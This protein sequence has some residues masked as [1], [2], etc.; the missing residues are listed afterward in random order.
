M[1]SL[2][3]P[4]SALI[5]EINPTQYNTLFIKIKNQQVGALIDK[6]RSE[7]NGL[8]PEKTFEFNFLDV[9]LDQQYSNFQ[10]FGKIIQCFTLIAILISCLGVYGLV[11]FIVK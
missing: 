9:Q 11:L 2:T 3:T 7:W 10:N 8:F 6:L 5:L 1:E 4:V